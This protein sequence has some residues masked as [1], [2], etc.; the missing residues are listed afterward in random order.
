MAGTYR[1]TAVFGGWLINKMSELT[2]GGFLVPNL[3]DKYSCVSQQ[4]R[5]RF[6]WLSVCLEGFGL[7]VCPAR[8]DSRL[9]CQQLINNDRSL[10]GCRQL[11]VALIIAVGFVARPARG[12]G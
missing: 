4:V 8:N 10:A 7:L 9:V 6:G 12:G 5:K 2:S 1:F 3:V 11:L